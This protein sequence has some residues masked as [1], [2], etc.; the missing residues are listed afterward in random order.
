MGVGLGTEP[1]GSSVLLPPTITWV[2]VGSIWPFPFE[3]VQI[4]QPSAVCKIRQLTS[5]LRRIA[6]KRVKFRIPAACEALA[7]SRYVPRARKIKGTATAAMIKIMAN[8]TT[9]SIA[10]N[11]LRGFRELLVNVPG[12]LITVQSV[13]N[14]LP[15]L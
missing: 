11:P 6:S 12:C 4:T 1:A 2:S 5:V 14:T 9:S 15:N 7:L 3:S 13:A 8:E 10:L